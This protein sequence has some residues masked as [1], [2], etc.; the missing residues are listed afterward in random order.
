MTPAIDWTALQ[1]A[2]LQTSLAVGALILL[3]LLIRRPFAKR[4]GAKAA[5][6]PWAIPFVRLILPPV[7]AEW[8]LFSQFSTAATSTTPSFTGRLEAIVAAPNDTV[9]VAPPSVEAP[10]AP[11]AP[12]SPIIESTNVLWSTL[13]GAP[14]GLI[15]AVVWLTG[16]V[17]WLV[18]A[19]RRQQEFH[20]LIMGDSNAPSAHVQR[21]A[22]QIQDSLG[23]AK[24]ILVRESLLCSGPLVTRAKKPIVLLPA[25]FEEDYT[26]AEQRDALTHEIM[27]VRRGD[28]WALHAANL[29]RA[30]QWFN[31]LTHL[32]FRAFRADQEA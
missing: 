29:F 9:V 14:W 10:L 11:A 4:F 32:A 15:L 2:A 25:W 5:Y 6:A 20:A 12:P 16:A 30:A 21:M 22:D 23:V 8:S 24:P 17:A 7:P 31:P 26:P 1:A 19:Q 27:H 18:V 3:V 13:A 28:L